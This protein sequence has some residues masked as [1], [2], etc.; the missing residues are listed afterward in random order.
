MKLRAKGVE[1]SPMDISWDDNTGNSINTLELGQ[2]M[3]ESARIIG[4]KV[5]IYGSDACLMAMAE[6]ASEMRESVQY[7]LGSQDLEPGA[8][9]PY[10]TILTAWNNLGK[11]A[12]A[13][14]ISQIVASE[15]TK[16]YQGGVNGFDE[17]TF[18]AFDLSKTERLYGAIAQLNKQLTQVDAAGKKKVLG[19]FAKTQKF[20]FA[21]YRDLPD[22]VD[23]LEKVGMTSI[24]GDGTFREI[25][26]ALKEYVIANE[27]T[28]EF[29]K[30]TG[31]SIWMTDSRSTYNRYKSY[32]NKL[33]FQADTKWGDTLAYLLG[34]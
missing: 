31:L 16:S 25:R 21:D 13:P 28:Q 32:Y 26:T 14:A 20:Y 9:W 24:L 6:V 30:A 1:I 10:D 3:A 18:S 7:Y 4:H 12:S 29:K 11:E 17:V 8:G 2:A 19:A 23:Q 15:Y 27:V 22:F 33:Q 5:D 34:E